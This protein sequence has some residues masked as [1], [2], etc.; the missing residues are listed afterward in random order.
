V[1]YVVKTAY[2][3]G[4]SENYFTELRPVDIV[5]GSQYLFTECINYFLPAEST[6]GVYFVADF[7]GI[8]NLGAEF[9]LLV[10]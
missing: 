10:R 1:H 2:G 3:R 4:V 9:R 5:I 8:D 7:I 6:G